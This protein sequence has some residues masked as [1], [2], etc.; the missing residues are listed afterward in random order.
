[1]G[2]KDPRV[3]AYIDKAADFAKP[4]LTKLRTLVHRGCPE[5]EETIKWGMPSFEYKG[6]F[7]GM[8]AFKQH[9][10]FG[11]WKSALIF[12][13]R[14]KFSEAELRLAWGAEGKGSDRAH[15]MSIDELPTDAKILAL[16]KKA[17]ELNDDG[18]KIPKEKTT[19][20]PIPLPTDFENAL[21]KTKGAK[22]NFEKFSPSHQR[23]YIAW[24]TG[25]KREETRR[26]RIATAAEWIAEGKSRNWKY[27]TSSKRD[28]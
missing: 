5:V 25:A 13:D 15:I 24:I 28:M 26:K 12:E 17:K 11:F 2:T 7:V 14:S 10:A 23:E 1:M 20:K 9:C 27:Q 6:P 16:I 4:I 22:A 8:A 19:K 3:D 18:V 21:K